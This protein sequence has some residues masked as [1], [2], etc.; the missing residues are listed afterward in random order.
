[1]PP[2]SSLRTFIAALQT[3]ETRTTQALDKAVARRRGAKAA[4]LIQLLHKRGAL[5]APLQSAL[6]EAVGSAP[7]PEQFIQHC[8]DGWPDAQ[9][10]QMRRT[11]VA[12]IRD[13]RRVRFAW[14]LTPVA[15]FKTEISD[16]GAGAVVITAL[17]PRSSLRAH[18]DGNID[19]VPRK[20]PAARRP[21]VRPR[22]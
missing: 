17:T 9:K 11:L 16:T 6:R 5:N 18:Q 22:K 15:G 13:G 3:G 1:M 8:I 20:A 2:M 10:E 7:L 14:G 19:V 4:G 21:A 12:A